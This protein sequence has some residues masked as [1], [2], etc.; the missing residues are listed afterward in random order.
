MIDGLIAD[1]HYWVRAKSAD[2]GTLQVVQ[3]S[4]V[5]GPTPE[6][7]SVIVPGSDQHHSPEDFEFI[8]HILAPSG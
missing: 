6:F 7:F 2:D 3:V 5:F 1:E 8:A 4:S